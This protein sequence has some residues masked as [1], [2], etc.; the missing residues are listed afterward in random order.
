MAWIGNKYPAARAITAMCLVM[1][2]ITTTAKT[3]KEA[4]EVSQGFTAVYSST[5]KAQ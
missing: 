2:A 5:N 1:T 4:V 3:S